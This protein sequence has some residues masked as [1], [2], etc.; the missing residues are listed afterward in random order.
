[1]LAY[2]RAYWHV[3]PVVFTFPQHGSFPPSIVLQIDGRLVQ[4]K[5]VKCVRYSL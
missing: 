5:P 3:V 1:M 4:W 2:E